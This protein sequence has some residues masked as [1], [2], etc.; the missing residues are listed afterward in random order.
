MILLEIVTNKGEATSE[1]RRISI[2]G[3]GAFGTTLAKILAE[4]GHRIRMWVLEEQLALQ[5]NT[6]HINSKYLPGIPL[7]YTVS[8]YNDFRDAVSDAEIIVFA[9]PSQFVRETASKL[10]KAVGKDF[11]KGKTVV[12]VA[13]GVEYDPARKSF[14][15]MTEVIAEELGAVLPETNT[16]SSRVENNEKEDIKKEEII[17]EGKQRTGQDKY[18]E[19][20]NNIEN[21]DSRDVTIIALSGPNLAEEIARNIP[22][23]TVLAG[24]RGKTLDE[25]A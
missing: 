20:E 9:V 10:V 18:D 17:K 7:P 21:K 12:N 11:F 14:K 1:A 5:L 2:I 13:K 8:A 24:R 25:T 19:N 3:A 4:K 6:L 15:R 22:T 23:A 16:P